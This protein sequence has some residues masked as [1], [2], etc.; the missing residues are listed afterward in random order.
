MRAVHLVGPDHSAGVQPLC[1][2][3]EFMDEDWT[4]VASEVRCTA[5]SAALRLLT[6]HAPQP[7]AGRG[8]AHD[9]Q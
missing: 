8:A 9:A 4:S 1:G 7:L 6:A 3:W 2:R 5:C